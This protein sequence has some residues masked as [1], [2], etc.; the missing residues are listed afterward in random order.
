M[1][2]T[3]ILSS[4]GIAALQG[5]PGGNEAQ[6]NGRIGPAT[7]DL[8]ETNSTTTSI[9]PDSFSGN[10]TY[11]EPE[12][13]GSGSQEE[14]P[15]ASTTAGYEYPA[16]HSFTVGNTTGWTISNSTSIGVVS[17]CIDSRGFNHTTVLRINNS[18]S[19][20]DSASQTF[21]SNQDHGTVELY[22][23]FNDT[24]TNHTIR[25]LDPDDNTAIE[26]IFASNAT[27]LARNDSKLINARYG[28]LEYEAGVWNHLHVEF[29]SRYGGNYTDLRL[30]KG[31][32]R[33]HSNIWINTKLQFP[34]ICMSCDA[35]SIKSL[36][37]SHDQSGSIGY[38]DAIDYS[39]DSGHNNL[40]VNSTNC[41]INTSNSTTYHD[42]TLING[43]NLTVTGTNTSLRVTGYITASS[44]CSTNIT[45]SAI[46]DC[47]DGLNWASMMQAPDYLTKDISC[48]GNDSTE[49]VLTVDNATLLSDGIEATNAQ[50]EFTNATVHVTG[51]RFAANNYASDPGEDLVITSSTV[52]CDNNF[53]PHLIN[54]VAVKF[55]GTDDHPTMINTPNMC[56]GSG[57][58]YDHDNDSATREKCTKVTIDHANFTGMLYFDFSYEVTIDRCNITELIITEEA[59]LTARNYSSISVTNSHIGLYSPNI[60]KG[61]NA[62]RLI[63]RPYSGISPQFSDGDVF[64]NFE[65]VENETSGARASFVKWNLS[66]SSWV[67]D[68]WELNATFDAYSMIDIVKPSAFAFGPKVFDGASTNRIVVKDCST[69]E[70]M[71]LSVGHVDIM[72]TTLSVISSEA[73]QNRHSVANCEFYNAKDLDWSN[74]SNV[75][76]YPDGLGWLGNANIHAFA[77]GGFTA[78][79]NAEIRFINCWFPPE[80]TAYHGAPLLLYDSYINPSCNHTYLFIDTNFVPS[81]INIDF[82]MCTNPRFNCMIMNT[83]KGAPVSIDYF[84]FRKEHY[85]GFDI[86]NGDFPGPGPVDCELMMPENC[87]SSSFVV[88]VKNST[89]ATIETVTVNAPSRTFTLDDMTTCDDFTISFSVTGDSTQYPVAGVLHNYFRDD[90]ELYGST[91]IYKRAITISPATP[92]ADYAVRIDLDSTFDF[93]SCRSD[94]GDLRFLDQSNTSLPYW[95]EQWNRGIN[96]TIWVKVPTASTSTITLYYGNYV[97]MPA[98][99]GSA[100]FEF[101]DDFSG[102][103]LDT[104][105]WETETDAK[106]TIAFSDGKVILHSSADSYDCRTLA[107]QGINDVD[108]D[109]GGYST[110]V[111]NGVFNMNGDYKTRVTGYENNTPGNDRINSTWSTL[112]FRWISSSLV[113]FVEEGFGTNTST[114]NIPASDLSIAYATR[115]MYYGPG[116]HWGSIMNSIATFN[117]GHAMRTSSSSGTITARCTTA[118]SPTSRSTGSS[119]GHALEATLRVMR[120]N[121]LPRHLA[122]SISR[123]TPPVYILGPST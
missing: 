28:S 96:A 113:Q 53:H 109:H 70:T 55:N 84:M 37:F 118:P 62:Q 72:N 58:S 33:Y 51:F 39:W 65:L 19:T 76:F 41:T 106:S 22:Y 6:L 111:S 54:G 87:Y 1:F 81:E 43:S 4:T 25:L 99:N 116:T 36:K 120:T 47:R 2:S 17:S 102:T 121:D 69:N 94:G 103:A 21:A 73:P 18:D 85:S 46:L 107:I 66:N 92:A 93:W 5:I 49:S 112:E 80:F 60:L 45:S 89:G 8:G 105:K 63:L 83:T 78:S 13:M 42:I 20:I 114:T 95:I 11:M 24:T 123:P 14:M 115:T 67:G 10:G 101:F 68:F 122:C 64:H 29:E 110:T 27:V 16:T 77:V 40:L 35:V 90:F 23:L 48:I 108:I 9:E 91:W 117:T 88:K 26:V 86:V 59:N 56:F 12:S 15:N 119:C 38:Y 50:V 7:S 100:T 52:T 57:G 61:H 32:A 34:D 104:L 75:S 44:G 31:L 97:A 3:I 79:L 74:K 71:L 30:N 98:S 82:C